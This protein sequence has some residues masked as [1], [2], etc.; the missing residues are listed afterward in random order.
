MQPAAGG[1]RRAGGATSRDFAR[2][3]SAGPTAMSVEELKSKLG[4]GAEKHIQSV[5]T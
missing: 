3:V 5:Y 1:Q 2:R 4:E